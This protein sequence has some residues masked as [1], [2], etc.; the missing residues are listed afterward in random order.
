M[1]NATM[2][3]VSSQASRLHVGLECRRGE[4]GECGAAAGKP[5][6]RPGFGRDTNV[7]HVDRLLTMRHA[8]F[9]FQRRLEKKR[10]SLLRRSA[11]PDCT[12]ARWSEVDGRQQAF[13]IDAPHPRCGGSQTRF[14]RANR[15]KFLRSLGVSA[16]ASLSVDGEDERLMS[17]LCRRSRR[18][19]EARRA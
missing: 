11:C 19:A 7:L 15:A 9:P 8:G 1:R 2:F 3:P 16:F 4:S 17:R 12:V 6:N 13:R 10:R 18:A 14:S 5:R